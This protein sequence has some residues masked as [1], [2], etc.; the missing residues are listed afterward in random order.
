MRNASNIKLAY[1]TEVYY[2]RHLNGTFGKSTGKG[3][4]MWNGLCPFHNDRKAGS[5]TINKM[6]GAFKCFSC[7]ARGGDII[8]FHQQKN[9]IG[10][11]EAL[12]QLWEELS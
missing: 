3:W 11:V 7:G 8:D 4:H 10:F 2:P 12:D 9:R 1:L 5:F 6:T